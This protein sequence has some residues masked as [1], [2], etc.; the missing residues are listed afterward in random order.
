MAALQTFGTVQFAGSFSSGRVQL[1]GQCRCS[2]CSRVLA[3]EFVA[4][5]L[6]SPCPEA[7]VAGLGFSS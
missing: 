2:E 4:G 6:L 1:L 7:S 3:R 5:V